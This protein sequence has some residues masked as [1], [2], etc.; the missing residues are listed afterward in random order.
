[1]DAIAGA[2][3]LDP[4]PGQS[5]QEVAKVSKALTDAITTITGVEPNEASNIPLGGKNVLSVSRSNIFAQ[6]GMAICIKGGPSRDMVQLPGE[7]PF[8]PERQIISNQNEKQ[9]SPLRIELV[10]EGRCS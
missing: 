5:S 9:I 6:T 1:M 8:Y 3:K 10:K 4:K 2:T 7:S